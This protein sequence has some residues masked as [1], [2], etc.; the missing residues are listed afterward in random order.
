MI[1]RIQDL[2][3][4]SCSSCLPQPTNKTNGRFS[5]GPTRHEYLQRAM[6]E[7]EATERTEAGDPR[8][9]LAANFVPSASSCS[10]SLSGQ[11]TVV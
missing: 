8:S 11:N 1:G 10:N 3:S 6:I 7:Q 5:H 4:A 2:E 9:K